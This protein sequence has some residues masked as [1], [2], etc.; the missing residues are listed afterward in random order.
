MNSLE[1]LL[2][3]CDVVS[4]HLPENSSTKNLMNAER[5]AQLKANCIFD[6]AVCGTV[7]DIDALTQAL[8][9]VPVVPQL[10]YSRKNPP[11]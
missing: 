9:S 7:V 11:D 6:N 3:T 4:L 8:E 2:S 1:E 5:I 10:M